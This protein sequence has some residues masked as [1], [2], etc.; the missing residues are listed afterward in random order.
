M[1]YAMNANSK[2]VFR[3]KILLNVSSL[4]WKNTYFEGF[5]ITKSMTIDG[6]YVDETCIF[7]FLTKICWLCENEL[8][9][10]DS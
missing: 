2:S 7:E 10:W 5:L 8:F 3:K 9:L 6:D 4:S 1:N